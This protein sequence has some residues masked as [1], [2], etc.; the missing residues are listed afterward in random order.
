MRGK[1]VPPAERARVLAIADVLGVVD[2]SAATGHPQ[3]TIRMWMDDPQFAEVRNK[4]REELAEG[5]RVLSHIT[6]SRLMDQVI[7]GTVEARDLT[8]LLGVATDKHLLMSGD[9]TARTETKDISDLDPATKRRLR[10]RFADLASD[11][12]DGVAAE[13]QSGPAAT[14]G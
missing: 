2:A 4:T 1:K 6:M 8:I 9:A 3:R 7:A 12:G 13:S 11:P 14:E 10:T 5:F